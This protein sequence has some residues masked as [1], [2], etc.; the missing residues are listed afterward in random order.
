MGGGGGTVGAGREGRGGTAQKERKRWRLCCKAKCGGLAEAS[1]G[2]KQTVTG[3][4]VGGR[5]G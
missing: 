5:G 2:K 4:R 3:D 1:G